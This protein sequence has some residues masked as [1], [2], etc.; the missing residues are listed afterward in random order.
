M[1]SIGL[2]PWDPQSQEHCQ[3]LVLQRT[4]C[5][6]NQ[7]AIKSWK[8]PQL[9][10][11]MAIHWVVLSHSDPE[12]NAKLS[13]HLATYPAES[14]EIMDTASSLGGKARDP[15][16][17]TFIPVGHISLDSVLK[18][19]RLA[20]SSLGIYHISTFYISTALQGCG[21]GRATMDRLETMATQDPLCAKVL[22]LRTSAREPAFEEARN[23]A[24]G[25]TGPPKIVSQ[26]WYQRRGYE[27]FDRVERVWCDKDPQGKKWWI[28]AVLMRR[29]I[30]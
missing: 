27:I 17:S 25:R 8:K 11:E 4:A 15:K 23:L 10:G 12:K 29:T 28:D 19:S 26:D 9:Q 6:W 14:Q 1:A 13:Q 3:R 7:K 30:A 5:G 24:L 2:I 20:D 21:L 16:L 22:T 18:D